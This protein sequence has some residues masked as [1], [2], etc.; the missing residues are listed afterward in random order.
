MPVTYYGMLWI[1]VSTLGKGKKEE[2]YLAVN[3]GEKKRGWGVELLLQN[4]KVHYV[5]GW[6]CHGLP[7]ELKGKY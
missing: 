7:I 5:P 6:D 4:Y 3:K 2:K 1:D